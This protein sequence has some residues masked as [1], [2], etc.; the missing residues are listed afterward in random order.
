MPS[1]HAIVGLDANRERLADI[2][3]KGDGDHPPGNVVPGVRGV[4]LHH[5]RRCRSIVARRV[6]VRDAIVHRDQDKMIFRVYPDTEVRLK[7]QGGQ[8]GALGLSRGMKRIDANGELAP[9]GDILIKRPYSISSAILDDHN[10]LLDPN[11][12]SYYEFYVDLVL[13]KDIP[14]PRLSPRLFALN[15]NDR[16]FFGSKIVGH[17]TLQALQKGR[18]VLFISTTTGEAPHNSMIHELLLREERLSICH[19]VIGAKEWSSAYQKNHEELM[20]N[21]PGYKFLAWNDDQTYPRMIQFMEEA[22]NNQDVAKKNLGWPVN[23]SN[24]HI[25][26]CGDPRLIGA[27]VKLGGWQYEYPEYGLMR[28]L[29]KYQFNPAS[30]FQP[31]NISFEA[32]W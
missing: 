13:E 3:R 16:I 24:T 23:A 4:Q 27:P 8:Y 9:E 10:Q 22:L 25:Y 17:Y 14:K 2:G 5:A 12:L 21:F 31:G 7:Y 6:D 30:R 15:D 26:L 11:K 32:Y 1:S 18:N 19:I 20:K 28:I 29:Q